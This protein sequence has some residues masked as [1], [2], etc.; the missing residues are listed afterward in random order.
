MLFPPRAVPFVR[1]FIAWTALG[2]YPNNRAARGTFK[3]AENLLQIVGRCET[4]LFGLRPAERLRRQVDDD[5]GNVVVA[6]ANA[7][8]SDAAIAWLLENPR[9]LLTTVAGRP[10]AIAVPADELEQA[11]AA[12][13]GDYRNYPAADAR[14]I[15]A[16]FIR[17]LR[18]K[19]PLLARSLADDRPIRIERDLFDDA[20]K[21]VT[22]LVTKWIWPVPAFWVTRLAARVGLTPNLVT[23][24]GIALNFVAAWFFY[25]SEFAAGV[26]AAWAMTFLDTVDGKLARV[27]ITSSALGN[28]LDHITDV[29]HPPLW[30]VCLA[31]GL[32]DA[33]PDRAALIWQSCWVILG[34]YV[35]GRMIEETFKAIIGFNAF[36]WRRFD[37]A[38]RLIVSRRNIILLIMTVGLVL[39]APVE[40]FVA[41]AGWS[42][43]SIIVQGVRF[44]QALM[45]HRN[46]P[47]S[48]WLS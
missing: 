25:R 6:D 37:S 35:A 16:R 29:L 14:Q 21:G 11:K 5:Q 9:H 3:K 4:R 45:A 26:V 13:T 43:F 39:N 28:L 32:A 22:D 2:R 15:G 31:L 34:T 10:L 30:W 36:L 46:R 42:V 41:A 1:A 47:L 20:Y 27:T 38:F 7:I 48:P 23:I 19:S 33:F 8:F 17:K 40:A 18:R 12:V 44:A 24:V